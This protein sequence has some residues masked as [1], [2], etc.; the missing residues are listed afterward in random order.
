MTDQSRAAAGQRRDARILG[1]RLKYGL[2]P[3]TPAVAAAMEQST[4][5]NAPARAERQGIERMSRQRQDLEDLQHE[6]TLE[7]FRSIKEP[8]ARRSAIEQYLG[9]QSKT[10]AARGSARQKILQ[11]TGIR[12]FRP[13]LGDFEVPMSMGG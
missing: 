6:T 11:G 9:S 4:M 10:P 8:F 3:E 13:Q 1:N 2:S 5:R 12:S 7:H